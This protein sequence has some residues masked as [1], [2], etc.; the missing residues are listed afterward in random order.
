MNEQR[1]FPSSI[2]P[3]VVVA[4]LCVVGCLNYLDRMMIT[5]MRLSIVESIPMSEAQFG[6]LT[7]LF[8]WIYGLLSPL[9]GFLADRFSR[10]KVIIISL[11]VW[12]L[13]TLMTSYV[14]TFEGLLLTRALMGISEACYIPAALALIADYHRGNSRSLATGIHMGGIMIGQSLGFIG[15]WLAEDRTWNYVFFVF[16]IVGVIYAFILL[17]TLRDRKPDVVQ[18]DRLPE[19][20]IGM[21]E[22]VR[23]LFSNRSYWLAIGFWGIAGVVTWMIA[24]WLPTYFQE[25]FRLTQRM[26]GVYATGYFY[27]ASLVGVILGGFLADRWS[28]S[29]PKGRLLVPIIGLVVA[30]PAVFLASSTQVLPLAIIGFTTY[31]FTR[32]FLDANMMP[33]L[34][35]I[36]D[37]RYRA[38]GYGIINMVSVSIGGMGIYAGGAIRDAHL[39]LSTLFRIGS[40]ALLISAALLYKVKPSVD[41]ERKNQLSDSYDESK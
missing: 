31:A 37:Q 3:W 22:A 24:G 25:H 1:L 16:G 6:L 15:G 36:V 9:S 26:A 7:S 32:T 40:V 10:S 29:H 8:L 35:L 33:I 19:K 34:C 28:R 13:V 12:S 17:V 5:T 23:I 11:F 4:L 2:Y 39:D 41:M 18:D 30:A 38:T 27:P 21:R 14:T 20:N